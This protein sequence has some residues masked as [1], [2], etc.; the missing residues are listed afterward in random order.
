MNSTARSQTAEPEKNGLPFRLAD[1]FK[2]RAL[3]IG[4]RIDVRSI[5]TAGRLASSPATFEVE[6]GGVAVVFRYGAIVLFGVAA[7]DE[8][9]LVQ[10]INAAV[11]D[12]YAEP[13][14]EEIEIRI[15]AGCGDTCE[16]GIIYLE[17]HTVERLQLIA[18]ALGTSV[19]LALYESQITGDLDRIEPFARDLQRRS[20]RGQNARALLRSIGTALLREQKMIGRVQVI[21]KPE[22]LWEQPDLDRFYR[23]L[24]AEFEIQE[25]HVAL[26]SKLRLISRTAETAL[27]VLQDRRA[28]R[29]EWYIVI[30]IL[31]EILL[32][33]Y[34]LFFHGY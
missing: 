12:P 29:V 5:D 2:A 9:A 18:D 15:D 33:V 20:L 27:Q 6:R 11:R 32:T 24:T 13:Q 21:D 34:E 19:A 26:E 28:L 22:L 3:L 10:R 1:A 23:R 7:E 16:D 17:S 30:L 25:R 4:E 14:T 31:V 8:A